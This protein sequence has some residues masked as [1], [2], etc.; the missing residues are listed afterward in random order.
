MATHVQNIAKELLLQVTL[1][2]RVLVPHVAVWFALHML[3]GRV[4]TAAFP[5]I[6]DTF[7]AGAIKAG[8]KPLSRSALVKDVRTRIVASIFAVYVVGACLLGA[9]VWDDYARTVDMGFYGTTPLT[10]HLCRL[11]VGFF[12]WD[13]YVSVVD[14]YGPA[15]VFHGVACL[16]VFIAALHPVMHNMAFIALAFEAST[17]FLH[18]RRLMIMAGRTEGPLFAFVQY[19]FAAAFFVARILIGYWQCYHWFA[20]CFAELASPSS[21]PLDASITYMYMVLCS[22]LSALN[23]WW[24]WEIIRVAVGS[25]GPTAKQQRAEPTIRDR[26]QQ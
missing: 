5:A 11:A 6:Y 7:N 3:F 2:A 8:K 16:C 12:V 21:P 24:M 22:G 15:F 26:K 20:R 18:G 23:G 17:P 9:F 1:N 25:A 19:G 10:V 4:I 13:T 14:G